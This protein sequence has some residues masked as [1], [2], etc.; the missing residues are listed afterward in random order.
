MA[1]ALCGRLGLAQQPEDQFMQVYGVIM[2]ADS[3]KDA[4][5]KEPALAKYKAAQNAL[6]NFQQ[7][8]PT[9]NSSV[10]SFRLSYVHEQIA[11]LSASA[12]SEPTQSG[13]QPVS[14]PPA[15]AGAV[16]VRLLEAGAEPRQVLRLHPKAGDKQTVTMSVA[17][18]MTMTMGAMQTPMKMPAMNTA[19]EV[20]V[21]SVSPAGDITYQVVMGETTMPAETDALPQ[22]V[23][24]LKAAL[25]GV[26]G[27]SGS[28]TVSSRGIN[29]QSALNMPT[30]ANPQAGQAIDRL[31]DTLAHLTPV[32]PEEPVGVGARWAVRMLLKSQGMTI[33]QTTTYQVV[34]LD[35]NQLAL[36]TTLTQNA[37]RQKIESPAAPGMKLDL[38][39]MTGQGSG[40][41][42][43][44]LG[45]IV[46]RE[47]NGDLQTD[48]TMGVNMGNQQQTL[49]LKMNIKVGIQAK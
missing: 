36:K 22:M 35:R 15:A 41:L 4:G 34:S 24:A 11:E 20:A 9:W 1:L 8:N 30:E 42:V 5:K 16:Q 29:R 19:L 37:P 46:P 49:G 25:G 21:Q 39:K 7:Q 13:S 40:Q 33:N 26:K 31:K 32:L 27:Q 48:M 38:V 43:A 12:N 6:M 18:D 14:R 17:T 23:D 44:D 2:Q 28:F 3:L 10:V 47:N 45:Q